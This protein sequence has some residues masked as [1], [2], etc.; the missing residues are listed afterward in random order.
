MACGSGH[1]LIAAAYRIARRL[2]AVRSGEDEP[3]PETLRS[4]LRDVN[5]HCIYGVDVNPMAVELCKV[6]LWLKSLEPGKPL[7]FLDSR[8]KCG[9]SLIGV[10]P[11]PIPGPFPE[12]GEGSDSPVLHGEPRERGASHG[13]GVRFIPDEGFTPVAGDHKPTASAFKKRNKAERAGQLSLMATVLQTPE[14]LARWA[15]ERARQLAEMPEDTA[16]QVLAKADE[17][18]RYRGSPEFARR[19]LEADLWTAAFFWPMKERLM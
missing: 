14:D 18:A 6:S 17:Y 12:A 1:F 2:A 4:A 13:Q 9:N 7:S 19:R 3:P 11:T 16:T 8:I 15:A 5:G 10:G